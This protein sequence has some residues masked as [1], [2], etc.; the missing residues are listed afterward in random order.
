MRGRENSSLI[1]IWYAQFSSSTGW[2]VVG[3]WG[4]IHQRPSSSLFCWIPSWAVPE[5]ARTFTLWFC[6][7]S[8]SL[9]TAASTTLQ[10]DLKDWRSRSRRRKAVGLP[11]KILLL[12]HLWTWHF[13][14]V[15]VTWELNEL[16]VGE[17]KEFVVCLEV[18]S[19]TEL[20]VV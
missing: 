19:V 12:H 1:T 2:V 6:P 20:E 17:A 11:L 15:F 10:G 7:T 16:T 13:N 3:T 4:T 14:L 5:W 9:R 8:I 18:V